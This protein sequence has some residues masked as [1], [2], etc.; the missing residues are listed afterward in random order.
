MGMGERESA[1]AGMAEWVSQAGV[2]V[3][4]GQRSFASGYITRLVA[5]PDRPSMS[6][7]QPAACCAAAIDDETGRGV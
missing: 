1:T 5:R 4:K 3:L 2:T 6:R 7:A